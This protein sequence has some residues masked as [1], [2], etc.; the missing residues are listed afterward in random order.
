MKILLLNLTILTVT[1]LLSVQV[2]GAMLHCIKVLSLKQLHT[3]T[4]QLVC[5]FGAIDL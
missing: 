2:G 1:T 3:G 5:H 4:L